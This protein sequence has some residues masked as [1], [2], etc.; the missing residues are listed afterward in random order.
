M[1]ILIEQQTTNGASIIA[2][3]DQPDAPWAIR[4]PG[5]PLGDDWQLPR[6]EAGRII[7]WS[8]SL[9]DDLFESHPL[10][11]LAPGHDAL[12]RFC[13]AAAPSLCAQSRRVCFQP[14]ARHV[15]S[16]PPSVFKFLTDR[17]GL[18]FDVLFSPAEMFEPSMLGTIEDHLVRMFETL[19]SR[20]PAVVLHDVAV[21]DDGE[22]CIVVPLGD[23][24]F[25]APL[26]RRLIADN[27]PADLP[28]I[29]LPDTFDQQRNWLT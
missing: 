10:T 11:W 16:D 8:G 13:D 3:P 2:P 21:S 22:S 28:I 18:P 20:V 4:A 1:R 26:V 15:L 24:R 7:C 14:H 5:N 19:G 25:P 27:C 29:L 23:G 9:A 12:A 6:T 17:E